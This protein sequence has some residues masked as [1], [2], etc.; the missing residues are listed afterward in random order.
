MDLNIPVLYAKKSFFPGSDFYCGQCVLANNF[1]QALRELEA[2]NSRES[3]FYLLVSFP[4]SRRLNVLVQRR[5][6]F[7]EPR[8]FR[9]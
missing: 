1:G 2:G 6:L 4:N 7:R 9:G 3:D 8:T 5:L